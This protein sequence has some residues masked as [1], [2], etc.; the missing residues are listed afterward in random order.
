MS[1]LDRS[2][3]VLRKFFKNFVRQI[4]DF[5]TGHYPVQRNY[6]FGYPGGDDRSSLTRDGSILWTG[7]SGDVLPD[8]SSGS[9]K[10]E[11]GPDLQV[12]IKQLKF[13]LS[14]AP[15][16]DAPK[17]LGAA[18][19]S[20]TKF[21]YVHPKTFAK[22]AQNPP[23]TQDMHTPATHFYI[24]PSSTKWFV[25][26]LMPEDVVIYTPNAMPGIEKFAKG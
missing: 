26:T 6:D 15:M 4:K 14:Q 8:F 9:A 21:A 18:A 23:A 24:R 19:H 10:T 25:T 5:W 11:N 12:Q 22:F 20:V 7:I 17:T 1:M 3:A 2:D 13:L 16:I